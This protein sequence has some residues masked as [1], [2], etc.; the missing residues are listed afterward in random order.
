MS[1][2]I[3][4]EMNK[5]RQEN[6]NL[7][8]KFEELQLENDFLKGSEEEN[9][10]KIRELQNQFDEILVSKEAITKE[11]NEITKEY[12][13]L[14]DSSN[15]KIDTLQSTITEKENEITQLQS[16]ISLTEEIHLQKIEEMKQQQRVIETEN[17]ELND[18]LSEKMIEI[19]NLKQKMTQSEELM[20]QRIIEMKSNKNQNV[21]KLQNEISRLERELEE[22]KQDKVLIL[23][24]NNKYAVLLAAARAAEER[25]KKEKEEQKLKSSSISPLITATQMQSLQLLNQNGQQSQTGQKT[26]EQVQM[27]GEKIGELQMRNSGYIEHIEEL[28]LS[29]QKKDEELQMWKN[30]M[31]EK[32]LVKML[33]KSI[34]RKDVKDVVQQCQMIIQD[35]VTENMFLQQSINELKREIQKLKKQN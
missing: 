11:K 27:L 31:I 13:A 19:E 30:Q 9:K 23:E 33:G 21:I 14:K 22:C 35:I 20:T 15:E 32:Y 26:E 5:I 34:Q 28:E 3:E 7:E 2:S 17:T 29:L 18:Q 16:T 4:T 6:Q 24:A 25:N 12:I 10:Q 8:M 1:N